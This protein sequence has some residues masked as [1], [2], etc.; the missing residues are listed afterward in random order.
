[1]QPLGPFKFGDF[2]NCV[3]GVGQESR[4]GLYVLTIGARDVSLGAFLRPFSF[5]LT[6]L[7]LAKLTAQ[8]S[9][10]LTLV[11]YDGRPLAATRLMN[12]STW[13]SPEI[14]VVEA[15]V[16][17]FGEH[18]RPFWERRHIFKVHYALRKTPAE[19]AELMRQDYAL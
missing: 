9:A 6:A 13:L 12:D 2:H 19:V 11:R 4:S 15:L 7:Q 3:L 16:T 14:A 17:R 10:K 18:T 8:L 5:K 1:M